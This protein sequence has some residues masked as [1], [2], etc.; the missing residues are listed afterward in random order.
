MSSHQ[1]F[2]QRVLA[3]DELDLSK[4]DDEIEEWHRSSSALRLS[5]WLGLTEDEYSLV[6]EQPDALRTILAARRYGTSL[7]ELLAVTEDA[8]ALAARG[9]TPQEVAKIRR[10][11]EQTGR[12]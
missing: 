4:I 9:A 3:G 10:W 8:C 12:L 1:S 6:V 5:E 11:L 2:V 7:Q